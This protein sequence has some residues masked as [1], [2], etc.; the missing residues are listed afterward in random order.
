MVVGGVPTPRGCCPPL[1]MR[2]RVRGAGGGGPRGA[3]VAPPASLGD[4]G[5]V[6]MEAWGAGGA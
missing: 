5:G 4:G 1:G 3:R 6:A 2:S